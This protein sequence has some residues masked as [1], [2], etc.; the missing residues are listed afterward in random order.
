MTHRHPNHPKPVIGLVGGI[1][2]GKSLVA[3]QLAG[4]GCGVIDSDRIAKEAL[5]RPDIRDTLTRWWPDLALTPDGHVDRKA[6]ARIV[7][8][9]P[10]ERKRLES[11]IHPIVH[12]ER[13]RLRDQYFR[14]PDT[15]AVVEDTPL[16]MENNL[17]NGCDVI[18]FVDAP[19][20]KRLDRVTRTRRWAP[21]ELARREKN[22]IGLDKKAKRA[23]YVIENHAAEQDCLM[24][25][26]RVLSQILQDPASRGTNA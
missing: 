22:Q 8:H 10:A 5:D 24:Q 20:E 14:D 3:R 25:V 11:L 7:F 19:A 17:D 9:D 15:T 2:S 1:G 4:L 18:V 26:R 21:D 23:D 16:L 13:D 6:L 12:R